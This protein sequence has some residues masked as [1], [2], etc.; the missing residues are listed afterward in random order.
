[1]GKARKEGVAVVQARSDKAVNEEGGLGRKI[2]VTQVELSR[3]VMLL[4]WDWKDSVL[5]RMTPRLL[6]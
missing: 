4:M 1:M 3:R 6:T 2:D 5:S